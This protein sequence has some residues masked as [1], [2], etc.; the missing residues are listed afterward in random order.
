[1]EREKKT[2][3]EDKIEEPKKLYEINVIE[4]FDQVK[5]LAEKEKEFKERTE[6]YMSLIHKATVLNQQA[7]LEKLISE[8]VIHI[9]ES[10]LAVSGINHYITMSDLVTLQKKCEK[11]L[12]IDYI[13]NFTRVIPDSVAE[14]KV[15][16]DNL[17]VFDNY[18]ILYY[19]PTGK[20]FSLT[21]YE[22]AEEERIKKDPILFGVIKDSDKLYYIDSWID[23][24]CD[25]TWDQVVEKLSEDKTL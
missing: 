18:V 23:D 13:K 15:L 10:V 1:M 20:S 24:L 19:D 3:T 14:K 5:I 2:I 4:L 8:L 12:D 6:A 9:Y 11:Q 17:Q 22:K 16:A 21:E 7:Q 25:L